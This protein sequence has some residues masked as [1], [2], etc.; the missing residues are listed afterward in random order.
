MQLRRFHEV[1]GDKV[2]AQGGQ[3]EE[4]IPAD[5]E[6]QAREINLQE[7]GVPGAIGR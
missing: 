1:K 2:P 5:R 6:R 4:Q 7:L 3:T